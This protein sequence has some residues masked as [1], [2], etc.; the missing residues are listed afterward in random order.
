MPDLNDGFALSL[1]RRYLTQR[2]A[3]L[4]LLALEPLRRA[5]NYR[6]KMCVVP[7]DQQAPVLDRDS[8]EFFVTVP[9]GS[10]VYAVNANFQT[11]GA[12]NAGVK[13]KV[14]GVTIF[15]DFI[16]GASLYATG[17]RSLPYH[18]LPVPTLCGDG[19]IIVQVASF[20]TGATGNPAALRGM[21]VVVYCAIPEE[22]AVQESK[23]Y[24]FVPGALTQR[25]KSV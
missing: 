4:A 12:G 20:G 13:L 25:Q 5:N 24:P 22:F 15:Y 2:Y 8:T 18:L 16:S 10:Y 21:Q 14:G 6:L 9:P 11:A 3:P 23:E 7:Q 17:E 1:S 19:L